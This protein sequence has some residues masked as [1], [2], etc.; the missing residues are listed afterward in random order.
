MIKTAYKNLKNYISSSYT[1]VTK[2]SLLLFVV[3]ILYFPYTLS[4]QDESSDE[5]KSSLKIHHT[6]ETGLTVGGQLTNENFVYKSG[7]LV[8]Y[9]A[10]MQ[11]SSRVYYGLGTGL[12]KFNDETF[13][14]LFASFKGMLK[15]KDNTSF[16][17]AQLGYAIGSSRKF[18]QY[19][20]YD[21][22]GGMFFSPGY[23]YRFSVGDAFSVLCSIHYKHQFAKIRYENFD[24]KTYKE[25][26]NYD[27]I[28]FRIGISL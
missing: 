1:L 22:N 8:Q 15:K 9:T 16:L 17:A 26:L 5:G 19:T 10:D 23:G 20:N 4:A 24:R 12:E 14:P 21:F 25:S 11:A 28:S 7:F 3:C 6:L 13:I 2:L 27:L 18:N